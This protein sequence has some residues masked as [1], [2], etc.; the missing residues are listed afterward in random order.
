MKHK[1]ENGIETHLI[2]K[3]GSQILA[4]SEKS[5]TCLSKFVYNYF[6]TG[7]SPI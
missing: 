6:K 3:I 4:F 2:W 1:I 5:F 7:R